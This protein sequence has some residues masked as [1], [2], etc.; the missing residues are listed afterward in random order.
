MNPTDLDAAIS[1]NIFSLDM[2]QAA[3]KASGPV[4]AMILLPL[5]KQAADIVNTLQTLKSALREAK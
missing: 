1:S 3:L 2:L 5:I 4:E